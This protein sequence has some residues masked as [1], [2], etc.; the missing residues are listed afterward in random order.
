[1]F[2]DDAV[3]IVKCLKGV[4]GVQLLSKDAKGALLKIESFHEDDFIPV[5][6]EGLNKCLKREF[7][8]VMFKTAE[9]RIPPEPTVIL[10]T[11]T[12]K[13]LGRELISNEDKENY[14]N[15]NDVI[16]LSNNFILFKP[17]KSKN[18]DVIEKQQFILPPIPFPEL[19]ELGEIT[20]IISGTPSTMGDEYIKNIYGYP[21]DPKIATVLI[22]FSKKED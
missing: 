7:C 6:N 21:E 18:R 15:R 4:L 22:G 3:N 1:M 8:L 12:G 14:S 13:I 10:K 11:D 5:I 2:V 9:F 19:D 16:F 17:E 20:D